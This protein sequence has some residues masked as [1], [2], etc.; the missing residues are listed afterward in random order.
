MPEAEIPSKQA[1]RARSFVVLDIGGTNVRCGGARSGSV[2]GEV[3]QLST[4]IFSVGDPVKT[5]EKTIRAFAAD[6]SLQDFDVVVGLPA[7]FDR[8][9][10]AVLKINNIPAF[11]GLKLRS[12]LRERFSERIVLEHDI[13]LQLIGEWFAGS[14][15]GSASVLGV[16]SGTGI[17][18]GF[19]LHGEPVRTNTSGV[20]LGHI[21]VRG[22]GRRCVCGLFDCVEA[23]ASGRQLLHWSKQYAVPIQRL[24]VDAQTVPALA[25]RLKEFLQ[26]QATAIAIAITLIDPGLVVL[27]GGITQMA[28]YQIEKLIEMVRQRLQLP[29]PA[30]SVK[31]VQSALGRSAAI[32]GGMYLISKCQ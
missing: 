25:E 3:R 20:E 12:I 24:F 6:Q 5:L 14:A 15:R 11:H 16:Y 19:L 18:G 27:G 8:D 28:G 31:F 30:H 13:V 29:E 17:G 10:D 2:L 9:M 1:E 22:E 4:D 32:Y 7:T 21:P 26:D 23:Y